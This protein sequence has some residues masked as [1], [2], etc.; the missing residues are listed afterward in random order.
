MAPDRKS[1]K[2]VGTSNCWTKNPRISVSESRS[3][4]LLG[5]FRCPDLQA[6]CQPPS[7]LHLPPPG[8][9]EHPEETRAMSIWKNYFM[10][11]HL[12]LGEWEMS[13]RGEPQLCP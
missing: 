12:G 11:P 6:T 2:S 9:G 4:R 5:Q 8:P 7:V 1:E 13:S 10:W 3:F